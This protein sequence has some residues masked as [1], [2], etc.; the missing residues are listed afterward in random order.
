M[1]WVLVILVFAGFGYCFVVW[2]VSLCLCCFG[3]GGF[4]VLR[5]FALVGFCGCVV[6]IHK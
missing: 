1:V 3:F 4:V 5:A 2:L 6:T